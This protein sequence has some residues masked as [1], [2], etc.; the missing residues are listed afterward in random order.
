MADYVLSR[1]ADGDLAEIF[2]YSF[3]TF[4][5]AQAETYFLDLSACLR[6]LADNPRL[7]RGAGLSHRDMLKHA[8]GSHVIY[9]LIEEP[10]IFVV[11]VLHRSMDGERHLPS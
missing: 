3:Q 4:G 7:G 2:T 6:M 8:H 9:Y 1:A 10:G 5:E 11:R